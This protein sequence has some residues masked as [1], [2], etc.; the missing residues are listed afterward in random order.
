MSGILV[1]THGG[2]SADGAIRVASALADRLGERLTIVSVIEPAPTIDSGA[3]IPYIGIPDTDDTFVREML[4]VTARQLARCGAAGVP[5]I[6]RGHAAAEIDAAA[7]AAKADLIVV[8]LGPHRFVDRALGTETALQLVQSASVPVLAISPE[9]RDL[10]T[11]ILAAV[12]FSDTSIKTVRLVATWLRRGDELVL[13]H[14]LPSSMDAILTLEGAART[15]KQLAREVELGL[16]EGVVV[17]DV[18]LEGEPVAVLVDLA[19][20][21]GADVIALGSHGYGLWKR[22]TLGSVAARL[23]RHAPRSVLVT[24]RHSL[25]PTAGDEEG[26]ETQYDSARAEQRPA[27][28]IA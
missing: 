22:L 9:S 1:A 25:H 20:R 11:C 8:G 19:G 6:R 23:I 14:V 3:G 15:L 17:R 24:P 12:D 10:P 7:R 21:M 28:G 18:I 5:Q 4:T 2:S 16:P 13:A 26:E 27:S